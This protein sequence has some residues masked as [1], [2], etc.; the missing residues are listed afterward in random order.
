MLVIKMKQKR[1]NLAILSK[2][3]PN[4]LYLGTFS[5]A[6]GLGGIRCGF[7]IASGN[8]LKVMVKLKDLLL[9]SQIFRLRGPL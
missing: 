2:N 8:F 3:D 6:Y 1:L 9:Y 4:V 7:G 5:K